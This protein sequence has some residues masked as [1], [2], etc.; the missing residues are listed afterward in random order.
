MRTHFAALSASC[1]CQVIGTCNY[2]W[3]ILST[4]LAL[5][6][7]KTEFALNALKVPKL[8]ASCL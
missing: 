2:K 4:L 1:P 3:V 6:N 5:H 7:A 8:Q